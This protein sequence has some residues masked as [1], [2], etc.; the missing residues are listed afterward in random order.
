MQG[1]ST[2]LNLSESHAGVHVGGPAV[3]S[4]PQMTPANIFQAISAVWTDL[5]SVS[6]PSERDGV[7]APVIDV[8]S[9]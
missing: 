4:L 5:E 1:V 8:P 9:W 2:C 6:M 7:C 3:V